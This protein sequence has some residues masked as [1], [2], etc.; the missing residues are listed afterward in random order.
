[1]TVYI[2]WKHRPP[3]VS[4]VYRITRSMSRWDAVFMKIGLL[5][6]STSSRIGYPL[7]FC[8]PN[9]QFEAIRDLAELLGP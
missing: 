2:F 1:M 6:F 8:V 9:R 7:S 3:S 5:A 4:G